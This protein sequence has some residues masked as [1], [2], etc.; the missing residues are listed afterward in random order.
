VLCLVLFF[1]TNG[2]A[3]FPTT[4]ILDSFDRANAGSLGADWNEVVASY[5]I[6]SNQARGNAVSNWQIANYV[7]ITYDADF[8]VYLTL[9]TLSNTSGS[10]E[11][12][13]IDANGNGYG[14]LWNNYTNTMQISIHNGSDWGEALGSVISQTINSGNKIGF[15]K[16]GSTLTA[17]INTGGGWSVVDTVIDNT[18]NVSPI[19]LSMACYR[20]STEADYYNDFGGGTA[21][22]GDVYSGRGFGRGIGRGIG[23]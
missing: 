2:W 15:S 7:A 6:V 3:A 5:S 17:Y 22:S 18:Y 9:N 16:V 23:R 10:G 1:A 13:G 12:Y 11:I 19:Y 4:G 14:V 21:V 8:E 20:S